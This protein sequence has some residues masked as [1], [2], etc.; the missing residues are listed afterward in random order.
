MTEETEYPRVTQDLEPQ[1]TEKYIY[2]LLRFNKIIRANILKER[3]NETR[4]ENLDEAIEG[5]L[6][7][8][9]DYSKDCVQSSHEPNALPLSSVKH[10]VWKQSA[11][12][13][14]KTMRV[15]AQNLE[16]EHLDDAVWQ[17]PPL[18]H[19][20]IIKIYYD[21]MSM[22]EAR[23]ALKGKPF[24]ASHEEEYLKKVKQNAVR[25]ITDI[26]N[27]HGASIIHD[28]DSEEDLQ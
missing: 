10:E 7:S 27:A 8:A 16:M 4:A 13:L 25:R 14:T 2:K 18:Q 12:L 9:T 24:M 19:A 17:L 15:D 20:I 11:E 23:E 22:T 5:K 26:F 3:M 28:F 21:R 1:I 6:L